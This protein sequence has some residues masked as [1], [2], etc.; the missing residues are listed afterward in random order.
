VAIWLLSRIQKGSSSNLLGTST[1]G[2]DNWRT[3]SIT[4]PVPPSQRAAFLEA[5]AAE[6][7]RYPVEARGLGLLHRLGRSLQRQFLKDGPVAVG[8]NN[9]VGKYGRAD[10]L[11]R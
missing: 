4:E 3:A 7:A 11:R 5:L 8:G 1:N 9:G 10:A 2:I 6:P